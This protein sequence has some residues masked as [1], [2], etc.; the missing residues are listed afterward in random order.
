MKPSGHGILQIFG[1]FII[2]EMFKQFIIYLYLAI[3]FDL[4]KTS[5]DI[6]YIIHIYFIVLGL[7]IFVMRFG[8]FQFFFVELVIIDIT[9]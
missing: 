3:N 9:F 7:D 4:L 1:E 8:I 5:G 2:I 6:L